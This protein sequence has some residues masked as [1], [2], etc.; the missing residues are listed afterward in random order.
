M[1][2]LRLLALPWT[3][4]VPLVPILSIGRL[5]DVIIV[6]FERASGIPLYTKF[7]PSHIIENGVAVFNETADR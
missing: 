6:N 5:I 3:D 2:A 4:C 1:M 7:E